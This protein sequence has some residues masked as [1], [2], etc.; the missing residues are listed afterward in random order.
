MGSKEQQ[1][2]KITL[3][4]VSPKLHYQWQL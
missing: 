4:L 2:T 1:G 3:G